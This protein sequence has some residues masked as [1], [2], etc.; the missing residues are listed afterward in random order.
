[1]V[2]SNQQ[3]RFCTSRD[4]TRIAYAI[5]GSGPMLIRAPHWMSSIN[6]ELDS[7]VWRHWVAL[8]ARRHTLI[9]FDQRGCGLSD[10]EGVEFSFE[11][12]VE[13]F[14]AV[15]DAVGPERFDLFGFSGGATTGIAYAA[16]FPDLVNR[17]I[18]CSSTAYGPLSTAA[19]AKFRQTA[20]IQLEAIE[21]GWPNENPAFRQLFTSMLIPDGTAEQFRL[22]NEHVRLTTPPANGKRIIEA[23][24]NVDI[25]SDAAKLRCPALVFHSRQDGRIPFEQGRELAGLIPGARFVPLES[26]N[27]LIFE[28]EP[29][30]K[31]VVE[32]INEF[33]AVSPDRSAALLFDELTSREREVLE[34][35]ARGLTNMEISTRLKISDKTVRNQVSIILS[36]LGVGSRAQ[37]VAVARDAGF[38]GER[39]GG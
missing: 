16:R 36:K 15:V 26:R 31:Q 19:T 20:A 24:W 14:E 11:R 28:T 23:I 10:R 39:R 30:W 4:G 32:A 33:L 12:F 1:V 25:R 22:F 18:I 9:R 7:P 17:F 37:A 13:D 34:L 21:L 27:H 29:A 6:L 38:A 3:I 8:L 35:V 2:L 5:C